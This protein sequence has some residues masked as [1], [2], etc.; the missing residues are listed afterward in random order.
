MLTLTLFSE[1]FFAYLEKR[2]IYIRFLMYLDNNIFKFQV[3]KHKSD[4]IIVSES[5]QFGFKKSLKKAF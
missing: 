2:K 4:F 1:R 3:F 5:R